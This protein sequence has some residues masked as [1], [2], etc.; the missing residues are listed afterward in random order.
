MYTKHLLSK[1]TDFSLTDSL[2]FSKKYSGKNKKLKKLKKFLK[3]AKLQM[4][5]SNAH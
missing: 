3:N 5:L 2:R 4:C 1:I